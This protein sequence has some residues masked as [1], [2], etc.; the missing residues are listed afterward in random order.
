MRIGSVLGLI[1]VVLVSSCGG[2]NSSPTGNPASGIGLNNQA[3]SIGSAQARSISI[4]VVPSETEVA[5]INGQGGLLSTQFGSII[6]PPAPPV[7][8]GLPIGGFGGGL[9][10]PT[11]AYPAPVVELAECGNGFL[12][13]DEQCDDGNGLGGDGGVAAGS[14]EQKG[15]VGGGSGTTWLLK[16]PATLFGRGAGADDDSDDLSP[17]VRRSLLDALC[18]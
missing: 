7:P 17:D 15:A 14:G 8:P 6:P 4:G 9:P 1:F 2:D 13:I 16:C 11:P 3:V 18:S 12:N 5:P 10:Y